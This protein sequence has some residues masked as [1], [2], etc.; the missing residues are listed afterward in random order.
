MVHPCRKVLFALRKKLK[1]E[2][3]RIEKLQ[4]IKS[5][6]EPSEWVSSLVIVKKKLGALRICLYPRD[7][8]KA[9]KRE[10]HST[11]SGAGGCTGLRLVIK[12]C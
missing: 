11:R 6:E 2:L 4:V 9:I 1:K 3:E 12:V 7:L 8:N 10:H 5:I